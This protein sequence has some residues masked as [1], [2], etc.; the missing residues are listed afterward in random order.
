MRM[1]GVINIKIASRD[2]LQHEVDLMRHVVERMPIYLARRMDSIWC[3]SKAGSGYSVMCTCGADD[4]AQFLDAAFFQA[5][6][7]HN[8]VT[9]EDN[10]GRSSHV[11]Q[12]WDGD[13]SRHRNELTPSLWVNGPRRR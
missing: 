1:R 9:V 4:I 11:E 2:G 13:A 6:G 12:R 7:G 5:D 3:D 10:A 8:G